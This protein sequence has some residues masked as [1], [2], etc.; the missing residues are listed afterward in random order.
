MVQTPSLSGIRAAEPRAGHRSCRAYR[1]RSRIRSF[2]AGA[3]S[4]TRGRRPA[5]EGNAFSPPLEKRARHV[6]DAVR[7]AKTSRYRDRAGAGAQPHVWC[8]AMQRSRRKPEP[9]PVLA[10]IL[11]SRNNVPGRDQ[12][13]SDSNS[14]NQYLR[15]PEVYYSLLCPW[16]SA[17][18]IGDLESQPCGKIDRSRAPYSA[19]LP[20]RHTPFPAVAAAATSPPVG[21]QCPRV[22]SRLI[23]VRLSY[24]NVT[25]P[26]HSLVVLLRQYCHL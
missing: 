12:Q 3:G 2:G 26:Q 25:P 6:G 16:I 1:V 19:P 18:P 20:L 15:S 23:T 8:D 17:L 10:P 24:A 22:R 9:V 4:G 21:V 13:I 14:S 5:A 11:V 7:A